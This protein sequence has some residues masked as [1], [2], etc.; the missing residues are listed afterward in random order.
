MSVRS[1]ATALYP[2]EGFVAPKD[3]AIVSGEIDLP[4]GTEIFY[5]RFPESLKDKV[6]RM[7]NI[8][9]PTC[10]RRFVTMLP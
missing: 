4:A 9:P 2:P 6:P 3:R 7:L 1:D 5:E 10:S 8:R